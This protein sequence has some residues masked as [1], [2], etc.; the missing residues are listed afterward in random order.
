MDH[1]TEE[2]LSR[3]LSSAPPG[4]GPRAHP[5]EADLASLLRGELPRPQAVVVVRHLLTRCP[6]C[7]QLAS[8]LWM[9]GPGRPS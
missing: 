4:P 2:L 3:F 5:S 1:L 9:Q 6:S 7:L 8:S